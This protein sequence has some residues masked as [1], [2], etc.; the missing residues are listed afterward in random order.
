MLHVMTN[1]IKKFHKKNVIGQLKPTNK[2]APVDHSLLLYIQ[3]LIIHKLFIFQEESS[4][5]KGYKLSTSFKFKQSSSKF[6]IQ[7]Q[8]T[9]SC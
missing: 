1:Q 3:V 2:I 4:W 8:V 5:I 9:C 6:N 7:D